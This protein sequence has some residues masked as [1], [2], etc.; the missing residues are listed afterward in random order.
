MK[1]KAHEKLGELLALIEKDIEDKKDDLR[2]VKFLKA[3]LINVK[4]HRKRIDQGLITL[5]DVESM[6]IDFRRRFLTNKS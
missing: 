1:A 3:M 4:L 2:K 6:L 5:G